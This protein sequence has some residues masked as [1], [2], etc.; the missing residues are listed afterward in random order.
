MGE[1]VHVWGQGA[2][3][4]SLFLTPNF[5]V[6]LKPFK[7]RNLFWR[8]QSSP[9]R[10]PLGF[11]LCRLP[12]GGSFMCR[13]VAPWRSFRERCKSVSSPVSRSF[14]LRVARRVSYYRLLK[15]I[16][17][18]FHRSA[19]APLPKSGDRHLAWHG[20]TFIS[21]LRIMIR[22]HMLLILIQIAQFFRKKAAAYKT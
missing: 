14:L 15:R 17:F 13:H 6:N 19:F 10:G 1:A 21:I 3:G 2:D 20:F 12:G 22:M 11:L 16:F 18:S 4:N 5:I 8:N 9:S 7:K